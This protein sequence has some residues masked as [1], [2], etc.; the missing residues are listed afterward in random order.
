MLQA[1]YSNLKWFTWLNFLKKFQTYY[2]LSYP[3]K[4][5]LMTF[6]RHAFPLKL[7]ILPNN[8]FIMSNNNEI[9]W[10]PLLVYMFYLIIET[11]LKRHVWTTFIV[12]LYLLWHNLFVRSEQ[13][14]FLF[15]KMPS[16]LILNTENLKAGLTNLH[17]L[18][19]C[20]VDSVFWIIDN[21]LQVTFYS[22]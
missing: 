10:K 1:C 22:I 5:S 13:C 17:Y 15:L 8:V 12:R 16:L 11:Y 19:T 18:W 7:F 6:L 4:L 14:R 3:D 9:K 2:W 21:G 20:F